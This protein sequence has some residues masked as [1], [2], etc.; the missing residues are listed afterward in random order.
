[1]KE[2][3]TNED[4]KIL[5]GILKKCN[6]RERIIVRRNRKLILNIYHYSRNK[7]ANSFYI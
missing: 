2:K 5:K 6:L 1:M 4:E 7:T 3:L